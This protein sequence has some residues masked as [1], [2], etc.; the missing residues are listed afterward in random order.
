MIK[1]SYDREGDLLEIRFSEDQISESEYLEETGIVIDYAE[2]GG[3]VALEITSF[4]KR[5]RSGQ[6]ELAEV[7]GI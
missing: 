6:D 1:L 5:I 2:N 4:S 3:L 7:V